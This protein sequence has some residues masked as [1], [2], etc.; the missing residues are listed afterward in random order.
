MVTLKRLFDPEVQDMCPNCGEACA[1]T[2]ILCPKCGKN[3]DE[4]F[5]NL[6]DSDVIYK[7]NLIARLVTNPQAITKWH[8]AN[9]IMLI[10]SLFTPWI[11]FF[12]DVVVVEF[13]FEYVIGLRVLLLPLI[14]LFSQQVSPM[15]DFLPAFLWVLVESVA[16]GI[17]IYYSVRGIR[18]ATQVGAEATTAV[19]KYGSAI[20]RLLFTV[21]S[22]VLIQVGVGFNSFMSFG[23]FLAIIGLSS[24][25][26]LELGVPVLNSKLVG[27]KAA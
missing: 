21:V 5:E 10:V 8:I 1:V 22:L 13:R 9:S 18:A 7:P 15:A 27:R 17:A 20:F 19:R 11:V 12:S 25:F 3:L 24:A 23:Y 26:L 2:A 4:L 14:A 6:A 16:P